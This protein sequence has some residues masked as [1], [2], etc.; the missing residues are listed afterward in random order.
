[1]KR[2]ATKMVSE[3]K[4]SGVQYCPTHKAVRLNALYKRG[5]RQQGQPWLHVGYVCPVKDCPYFTL[6]KNVL[7]GSD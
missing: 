4:T 3:V 2:S 7:V 1:M 6:D 5:T